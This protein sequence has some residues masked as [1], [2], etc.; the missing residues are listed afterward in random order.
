MNLIE[1]VN[2]DIKKAKNYTP[3]AANKIPKQLVM[4][5]LSPDYLFIYAYL[6]LVWQL[7]NFYYDGYASLIKVL[8]REKFKCNIIIASLILFAVQIFLTVLY[9]LDIL[10][11]ESIIICLTVLNFVIPSIVLLSI[12]YLKCKFSGIPKKEEYK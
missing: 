8:F 3:A 6:M 7:H 9:I 4:L 11:A 2:T 12:I 1:I 10:R 5:I